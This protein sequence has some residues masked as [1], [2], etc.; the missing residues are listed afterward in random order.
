MTIVAPVSMSQIKSEFGGPNNLA[1]YVRGGTYV[2][3]GAKNTISTTVSGLAISQFLGA[4]NLPDAAINNGP[5]VH[6]RKYK[7]EITLK[8]DGSVRNTIGHQI[9]TWMTG[10]PTGLEFLYQ[11]YLMD[12][13]CYTIPGYSSDWRPMTEI[14]V[15][16]N[17]IQVPTPWGITY[18]DG[19]A[20]TSVHIRK[21][22]ILIGQFNVFCRGW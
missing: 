8:M 6:I 7:A 14:K 11:E 4:E 12:E 3:I 21:N 22:G 9:G 17:A 18:Y 19:I 5:F 16:A 10:D 2:P 13:D 1:A 15:V 20:N